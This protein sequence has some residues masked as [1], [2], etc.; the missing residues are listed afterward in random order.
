[1][2]T[3]CDYCYV[4]TLLFAKNNVKRFVVNLLNSAS[5][6]ESASRAVAS[7]GPIFLMLSAGMLSISSLARQYIFTSKE[8]QGTFDI[9]Y[10]VNLKTALKES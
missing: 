7:L 9:E 1:M 2:L 10:L 4:K 6:S 5:S 3:T 8:I